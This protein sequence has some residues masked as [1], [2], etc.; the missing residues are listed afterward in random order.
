MTP[1]AITQ[2][3]AAD[4]PPRGGFPKGP[5]SETTAEKRERYEAWVLGTRGVVPDREA[6]QVRRCRSGAPPS[7][8]LAVAGRCMQCEHAEDDVGFKDRISGCKVA[9]CGLWSVR[10]Y[11]PDAAGRPSRP[12]AIRN[13]CL[14]CMGSTRNLDPIRECRVVVCAL[15]PVRPGVPRAAG[16]DEAADDAPAEQPES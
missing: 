8:A 14:Q 15:W 9:T 7:K 2:D 13:Y 16:G 11:R 12:A 5:A 3:T 4:L 10:P 1:V 6:A